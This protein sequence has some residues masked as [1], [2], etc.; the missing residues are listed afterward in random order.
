MPA[1]AADR[2]GL[3]ELG[4]QTDLPVW[5]RKHFHI[6]S[7]TSSQKLVKSCIDDGFWPRVLAKFNGITTYE[8]RADGSSNANGAGAA[9]SGSLHIASFFE[10]QQSGLR[11][12]RATMA[13]RTQRFDSVAADSSD[14]SSVYGLRATE[15][16]SDPMFE[17][18]TQ[19]Y[20]LLYKGLSVHSRSFLEALSKS[21]LA[22]ALGLLKGV[23]Q[24]AGLRVHRSVVEALGEEGIGLGKNEG[25]YYAARSSAFVRNRVEFVAELQLRM[26]FDQ[27]R[28]A[29]AEAISQFYHR[30]M[31]G[32]SG[33]VDSKCRGAVCIFFFPVLSSADTQG[34]TYIFA[35]NRSQRPSRT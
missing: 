35:L 28:P 22:K 11:Q 25:N 14:N 6:H 13:Y 3:C 5:T 27:T 12:Q 34:L 33:K 30:M 24:R 1:V 19:R 4:E 9:S 20:W 10:A 29:L 26:L 31:K 16:G 2:E 7:D 32:D 18:T 21:R 8:H 23:E 15:P 17:H